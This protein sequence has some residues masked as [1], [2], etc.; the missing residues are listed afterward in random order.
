MTEKEPR[1]QGNILG[2]GDKRESNVEVPLMAPAPG[3]MRVSG[4]DAGQILR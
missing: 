2:R 3:A 1:E 4:L